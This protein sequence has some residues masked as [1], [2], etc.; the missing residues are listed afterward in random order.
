LFKIVKIKQLR[1][2]QPES[3]LPVMRLEGCQT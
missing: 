1:A 2:P 3:A